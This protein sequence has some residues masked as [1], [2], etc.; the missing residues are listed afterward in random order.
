MTREDLAHRQ[1]ALV[2][3]L[4]RGAAVPDGFDQTR[5]R[6]AADALMRKRAD[7]V[8]AMWPVLRAGLGPQWTNSFAA[9][10]AGRPP[11]GALRDGWD[12]ARSL[13]DGWD[14]AR[15]LRDGWDFARSLRATL[16]DSARAAVAAELARREVALSY[17]GLGAPRRRRAPAL[18]RT[19]GAVVVQILGLV[20]ELPIRRRTRARAVQTPAAV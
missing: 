14:F 6:V 12:F 2:A 11:A 9:W 13:R 5:V 4:V 8:A 20:R 16:D 10:A 19:R 1:A 17:D 15:S 3:A 7:E 18:R